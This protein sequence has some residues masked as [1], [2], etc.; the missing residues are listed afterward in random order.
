[1]EEKEFEDNQNQ[2]LEGKKHEDIFFSGISLDEMMNAGVDA[3][4][5]I[6]IKSQT[7][8]QM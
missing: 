7:S 8:T 5:F 2:R 6:I 3:K 1:M 4:I